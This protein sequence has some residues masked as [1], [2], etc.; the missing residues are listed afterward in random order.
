MS[1]RILELAKKLK[2]LAERGVG[3]ERINAVEQLKRLIEKYQ[4]DLEDINSVRLQYRV[5]K[6]DEH[7][8]LHK[9]FVKQIIAAV[10]GDKEFYYAGLIHNNW[11][12]EIDDFQYVE[13]AE[14]LDFYWPI[15][16]SEMDV[17]YNAFIKKNDLA[18]VVEENKLPQ[19]T[20]EE[21]EKLNKEYRMMQGMQKH[22]FKKLLSDGNEKDN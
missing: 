7:N 10:V 19:L 22:Q 21:I 14:K 17:F 20:V 1:D 2:A 8:E 16:N 18:L 3:G 13:I 15:F 12:V 4:L 9:K 5:F 6:F 11:T